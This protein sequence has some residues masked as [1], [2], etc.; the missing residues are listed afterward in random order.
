MTILDLLNKTFKQS[1]HVLKAKFITSVKFY[2][3]VPSPDLL[4]WALELPGPARLVLALAILGLSPPL[5]L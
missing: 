1:L 3:L 4:L 5:Q 2:W